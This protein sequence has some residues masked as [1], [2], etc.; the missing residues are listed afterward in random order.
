[1]IDDIALTRLVELGA[2]HPRATMR[3]AQQTHLIS[4][5]LATREI[6]SN[7]VELGY[8]AALQGDRPLMEQTVEHIR[9][10]HKSALP[11]AR[12]VALGNPP[13]RHIPVGIRDRVLK[14]LRDAGIVENPARGDWRIINPLL[15]DYLVTLDAV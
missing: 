15:R 3:I 5:Q 9:S 11:M 6:T 10:L 12:A 13:P 7:I 14:L 8:R 2:S 4:V 1:M